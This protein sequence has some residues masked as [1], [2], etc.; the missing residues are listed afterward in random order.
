VKFANYPS[1][2]KAL[3][4]PKLY[5]LSLSLNH[6]LYFSDAWVPT[7]INNIAGTK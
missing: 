3:I 2:C 6:S 7:Q 1:I 5:K 4:H